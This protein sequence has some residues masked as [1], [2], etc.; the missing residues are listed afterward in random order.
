MLGC[1]DHKPAKLVLPQVSVNDKICFSNFHKQI[2][3]PFVMYGDI[4]AFTNKS[5]SGFKGTYQHHKESGLC[6][7][8]IDRSTGFSKPNT[9]MFDN[10]KDFLRSIIKDA[11]RC[12]KIM[13]DSCG[14]ECCPLVMSTENEQSFKS[15]SQ[16][17]LCNKPFEV[18][19]KS[20]FNDNDYLVKKYKQYGAYK[21]ANEKVRDHCHLTGKYR[22][23][24][25][26]KCNLK[27]RNDRYNIDFFFHNGKRL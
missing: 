16:C 9:H 13:K 26:S 2:A 5:D 8:L 14:E 6:Y 19:T 12:C 27:C 15:S 24:A 17:Y 21:K 7:T 3:K 1:E 10:S 18:Y 25:H 11:C 23:A 20:E 22:G 4:E